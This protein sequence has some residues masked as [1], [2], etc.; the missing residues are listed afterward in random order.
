MLLAAIVVAALSWPADSFAQGWLGKLKD[1]A[2]EKWTESA[3]KR[4]DKVVKNGDTCYKNTETGCFFTDYYNPYW[5]MFIPGFKAESVNRRELE[6]GAKLCA[7]TEQ[8]KPVVEVTP[9]TSAK[10]IAVSRYTNT[11]GVQM[12][13]NDKFRKYFPKAAKAYLDKRI[14]TL[15]LTLGEG[16]NETVIGCILPINIPADGR[17][18]TPN[19]EAKAA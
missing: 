14:G 2:L 11:E 7:L 13:V 18:W 17:S 5:C 16:E 10:G 15:V 4:F 19:E 9:G 3:G 12:W 8:H 1:K 6:L